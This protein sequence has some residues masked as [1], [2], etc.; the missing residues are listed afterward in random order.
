MASKGNSPDDFGPSRSTETR[1]V[2]ALEE[3]F[4]AGAVLG[5]VGMIITGGLFIMYVV[6]GG[7]LTAIN[8]PIAPANY[9]S[10]TGDPWFFITGTIV[11][12]F[13]LL[14]TASRILFRMLTGLDDTRSKF[15]LILNYVGLGCAAGVLR[16]LLPPTIDLLLNWI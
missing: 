4:H 8:S 6:V 2:E 16:F 5:T 13:V 10:M 12:T 7:G 1:I 3:G 14:S 11:S 15:V 9:L